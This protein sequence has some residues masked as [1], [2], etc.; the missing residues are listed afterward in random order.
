MRFDKR[1]GLLSA[2]PERFFG[3]RFPLRIQA[4]A[5]IAIDVGERLL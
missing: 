5:G 3:R 2:L 1:S 4:V